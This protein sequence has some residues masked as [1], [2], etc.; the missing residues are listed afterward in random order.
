ML[1][2]ERREV[3]SW[4]ERGFKCL[5]PGPLGYK[6]KEEKELGQKEAVLGV[7]HV[8]PGGQQTWVRVLGSQFPNTITWPYYQFSLVLSSLKW[9]NTSYP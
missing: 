1:N 4:R 6:R 8:E 2:T 5:I 9:V 3:T 7:K